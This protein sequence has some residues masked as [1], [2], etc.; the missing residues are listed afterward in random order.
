MPTSTADFTTSSGQLENLNQVLSPADSSSSFG[1]GLVGSQTALGHEDIRI[2]AARLINVGLSFLGIIFLLII[3]H[4]GFLW[5]TS[6]G[7][8]EAVTKSKRA[9]WNAI[10][11]L[12]IIVTSYSIVLFVFRALVSAGD[13]GNM[14]NL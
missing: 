10:V 4:S 8:E 9:L 7:R 1:L 11:G 5:L 12:F 3:L 6:G 2:I 14:N 13:A